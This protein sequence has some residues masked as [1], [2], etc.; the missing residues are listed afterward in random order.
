MKTKRI[1]LVDAGVK[2]SAIK[3]IAI[4]NAVSLPARVV[5]TATLY[6]NDDS[7]EISE[8]FDISRLGY[9]VLCLP[10]DKTTASFVDVGVSGTSGVNLISHLHI[11]II[12]STRA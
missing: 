6:D 11:G 8:T 12:G 2:G 1:N 9:N 10:L 5:L 3:I 4:V 7:R